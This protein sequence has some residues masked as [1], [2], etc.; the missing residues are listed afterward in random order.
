[1]PVAPFCV[2]TPLIIHLA[3]GHRP[4]SNSSPTLSVYTTTMFQRSSAKSQKGRTS[5]AWEADARGGKRRLSGNFERDQGKASKLRRRDK[6]KKTRRHVLPDFDSDP[7]D[8]DAETQEGYSYSDDDGGIKA[9]SGGKDS[10]D[11]ASENETSEDQATEDQANEDEAIYQIGRQQHSQRTGRQTR[12]HTPGTSR[13]TMGGRGAQA[14][15]RLVRREVRLPMFLVS[16]GTY[17]R[18][19][20]T[21]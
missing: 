11:E 1:M 13:K 17:T 6:I 15:G 4:S 14:G 2:Q 12:T 16:T 19:P 9:G 18:R 5:Q 10:E 20:P 7:G 8:H 21:N 3:F